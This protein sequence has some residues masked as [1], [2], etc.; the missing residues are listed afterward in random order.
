[1][2]AAALLSNGSIGMGM[3]AERDKCVFWLVFRHP[4][5]HRLDS[6]LLFAPFTAISTHP[7][8]VISHKGRTDKEKENTQKMCWIYA[9]SD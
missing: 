7:E 6:T 2:L 1:M 5:C 9:C 3:L 8:P 4:M